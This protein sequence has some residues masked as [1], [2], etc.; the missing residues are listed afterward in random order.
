MKLY[1]PLFSKIHD[2]LSYNLIIKLEKSATIN[3][4]HLFERKLFDGM[5]K[6]SKEI[7]DKLGDPLRNEINII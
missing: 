4:N 6:I 3:F 5:M 1:T 7:H 2:S